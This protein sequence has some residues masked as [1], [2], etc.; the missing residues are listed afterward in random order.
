MD[1]HCRHHAA[2]VAPKTVIDM[3]EHRMELRN[4]GSPERHGTP[5]LRTD[6]T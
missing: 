4:F 3:R 2:A 6:R 5:S 1:L